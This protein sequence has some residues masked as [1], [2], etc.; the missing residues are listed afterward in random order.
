MGAE[1]LL[2]GG[3]TPLP[4]YNQDTGNDVRTY[5]KCLIDAAFRGFQRFRGGLISGH[6]S[7]G[8]TEFHGNQRNSRRYRP[9]ES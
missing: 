7:Y 6:F 5:A 9:F 2:V 4:C 3:K 8:C 1:G